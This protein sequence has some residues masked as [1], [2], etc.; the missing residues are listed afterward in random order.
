MST[1]YRLNHKLLK[2]GAKSNTITNV[3]YSTQISTTCPFTLAD[4]LTFLPQTE[5][6]TNSLGYVKFSQQLDAEQ[7]DDVNN[8]NNNN[9]IPVIIGATGVVTKGSKNLEAV[10]GKH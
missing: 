8:N 6:N 1:R 10:P 2:S 9:N 5:H 4:R 3:S 7:C